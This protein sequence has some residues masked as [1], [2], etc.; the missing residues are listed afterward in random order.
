MEP[1]TET[2]ITNVTL[3]KQDD[4]R[5]ERT[6]SVGI[7]ISDPGIIPAAQVKT[8]DMLS[9]YDYRLGTTV[10]AMF[11]ARVFPFNMQVV[12]FTFFINDD[13]IPEG[14]EAFKASSVPFEGFPA[15]QGPSP[16]S[17]S[18]F[19][20]TEIR[21]VDNECKCLIIPATTYNLAGHPNI[22]QLGKFQF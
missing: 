9:S 13:T 19:Q 5:S 1:N 10:G 15:Y 20:T 21:I 3:I 12:N 17:T 22:G 11:V 18:A 6:F 8:E 2:L 4:R 7:T 14:I 16:G